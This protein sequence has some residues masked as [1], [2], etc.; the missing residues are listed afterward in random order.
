MS[1]FGLFNSNK[2]PFKVKIEGREENLEVE[3]GTTILKAAL[4]KDIKIP[5]KC[6][7]G[8]CG[9]CKCILVSG[10]VKEHRDKA[11]V[12]KPGEIQENYILTCQTSPKSD[13][14]IRYK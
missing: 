7:M 6:K 14:E 10:K 3:K 8:S 13:L 12:L 2:G 4:D 1:F 11:Y 9:R 5:H